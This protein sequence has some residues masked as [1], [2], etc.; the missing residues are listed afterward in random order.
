MNKIRIIFEFTFPKNLPNSI[1]N[2]YGFLKAKGLINDKD[3]MI[4]ENKKTIGL[5]S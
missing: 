1:H 4:I 3:K 2:S 5:N